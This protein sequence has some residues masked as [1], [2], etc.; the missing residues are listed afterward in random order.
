LPTAKKTKKNPSNSNA[1]K[2]TALQ[3]A[4]DTISKTHGEDAIVDISK[5]DTTPVPGV[6][7]GSL[8]LDLAL[9]G[10][11]L[12]RGRVVEL[13]G[14]ESSGKSTLALSVIAQAQKAGGF[15]LYIDAE[16]AFDPEY[17]VKLGVQLD[18]DMM[19]LSQPSTG[20]EGLDI[21]EQFVKSGVVDVVIIDSVAALVPKAEMAGEIGDVFVGV[22][23]RMMSQALRRLTTVIGKTNSVVVF[24]NQL[25]EKIGVMFGN[26]ETTPGG[27]ALKFYASVRIDVRR[28]GAIK[29]GDEFV[30]NRT[31]ATVVKNKVAPPFRKCEFDILYNKGISREGDIL[32]M[33]EQCGVVTRSGSW[34]TYH[35]PKKEE[36][37]LGQGREAARSLLI[38]N[39]ELADEIS[40]LVMEALAPVRTEAA[41][42]AKENSPAKAEE[43]EAEAE[44]GKA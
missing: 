23:A 30:G 1:D 10:R 29:D 42:Q 9:G 13:Y 41:T 26:P 40:N 36:V 6:P 20:E 39:P 2:L 27:R 28:I 4:I 11:G 19:L 44:A 32:D 31:K 43:A 14:P 3:S 37:R 22:Q 7:T 17:A 18:G 34:Y 21:C 24:I 25:R 12:P 8:G 16:H 33:G 15:C 5:R 35:P 38:E